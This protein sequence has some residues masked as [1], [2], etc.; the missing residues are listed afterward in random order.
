[1][2]LFCALAFVLQPSAFTFAQTRTPLIVYEAPAEKLP[3]GHLGPNPFW[4]VLPSG[5]LVK[6]AGSS[7]T[8]AS[9]ALAVALSPDG[10]YAFVA[11]SA[12]S[13]ID[14][15]TMAVVSQFTPPVR[16]SFTSVVA[17]RD[18]A[19]PSGMLI[20]AASGVAGAIYFIRF[21]SGTLVA[22]SV[23]PVLSV[24]G[25]PSSLIVAPNG[26]TVYVVEGDANRVAAIDLRRRHVT[27][28]HPVGFFPLGVALASNRLLVC[29]EGLMRYV[30]LSPPQ[31]TPAYRPPPADM[32]DASSMSLLPLDTRGDFA[33]S[34]AADALHMDPP[35][36]GLHIVG[37]AH[38]NAVAVTPDGAY[39]FVALANVDRV[40]V[41]SL[42]GTPHVVN[43]ID[44]RLFPRGPFGSE[45]DALALS[46]D[47]KRL[48]VAL[49]G[50]DAIAVLDA[51]TPLSLKRLGLIPTG[52]YPAALALSEDGRSLFVANA[53]GYG[54]DESG[55]PSTLQRIDLSGLDLMHATYTALG[56]ARVGHAGSGTS[57]V[58]ALGSSRGSARIK[59]V[60]MI[61][62]G[63]RTYDSTFGDLTD[64]TGR[65][66][67]N[68]DPA[69]TAFGVAVT[70]N[71]HALA[72]NF[73]L[74]DNFYSEAGTAVLGHQIAL[75]GIADD[76]SEKRTLG[77]SSPRE[78]PEDYARYGYIFNTL[79]QHRLTYRDYGE[80]LYLSGYDAGLYTLDVPALSA[81]RGRVDER[82]PGWNPAI[83]DKHRALEF[84]RDYGLLA[85]TGKTPRFSAIWLPSVD[86]RDGDAALGIIVS[87]ITRLPSWKDTAI[88]I[89][90]G[91]AASQH[92]HVSIRR[93]YAV[94][95]SPYAKHG[96][97]GHRHLATTSVLKTEE[98]LLG[99]PPLSLG[100]LLVTDMSDFFTSKP[101]F[102]P[103]TS[104]AVAA[105]PGG[106]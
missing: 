37:G 31:S 59:H 50:L 27:G 2:A 73:A 106:E 15:T 21:D 51:T 81:L 85:R 89:L 79:S 100:D 11:G 92:D 45:P 60:V 25:F 76:F 42:L 33:A 58:P 30:T 80:L 7:V 24:G 64:E 9:N 3:A 87:H 29:N 41:V 19:D 46:A 20:V 48:Y 13:A 26:L 71:L 61:L 67:G 8:V 68:G 12:L 70:P 90:P 38:P 77:G 14:V 63:D 101:R 97:V 82:Y 65:A 35:P 103:F 88:F 18:P 57:I 66:H 96:Y 22:D 40:A 94:V 72:R 74:A 55:L 102:A 32:D 34:V 98:E 44:L 95:V 54:P 43:G 91:Y 16:S 75:G 62:Q 52:D 53:K 6:P 39:A 49:A 47:G 36:D 93:S 17:V 10:R 5:R 86:P 84:I 78:D 1:V 23:M 99:L 69:M 28:T 83:D 105:G 4:A 104:K 56:D